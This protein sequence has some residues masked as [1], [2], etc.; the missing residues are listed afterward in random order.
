MR[1]FRDQRGQTTILI[2]LCLLCL[3]GMTGFAVDAGMMFRAKR[4]LQ[5]AADAA[6]ISGAAELNY[7]DAA[8]AA[9]AAA[10]QNGETTG[11]NGATVTVNT[12][13]VYGPFA[14]KSGY[15]EVIVSQVE[16]TYFMKALHLNS[17]TVSARAVGT[18]ATTPTCLVTLGAAAPGLSVTNGAAL[19]IS[20]CGIIDDATGSGALT[21]S[22][23]PITTTSVGVVGTTSISNGGTV[24]PTPVTGITTV[25]DPLSYFATPPPSSDYTSGCSADPKISTS[26]TIGPSTA[27]SYVCYDGLTISNSPTVTLNPGLY[28]INGVGGSGKNVFSVAGGAIVNGTTGVTFYFVNGASFNFSNG[29]SVNLTAPTSGPYR[30][31]LFYQDAGDT[32][33]DSFVGGSVAVLNGIFY[34]PKAALTLSNGNSTTFSTDL[35]VGSLT[36]TGSA[37]LKPYAPLNTASPLSG[38]RLVE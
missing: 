1:M 34:L 33:A 10:V 12:P 32:A 2:A 25:A 17:L 8:A 30:G 13:P 36:M 26:R 4:N 31:L 5:I 11:A 35:V 27:G 24:T 16:P 3:C 21:A 23:A 29:A 14:T 18:V 22:C 37:T 28:I 9:Q 7:G 19:S 6:A 38:A 20:S 15:V